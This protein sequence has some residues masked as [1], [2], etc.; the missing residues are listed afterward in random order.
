[1][2][3]NST[4]TDNMLSINEKAIIKNKKEIE[5]VMAAI[6]NGLNKEIMKDELDRLEAEKRK[7]EIE[8]IRLIIK[9]KN[10]PT[11][12]MLLA[13][14]KSLIDMNS[15]TESQKKRL[16]QRFVKKSSSI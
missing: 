2:A 8:N 6:R 10:K 7:L 5:N 13:F 16:I 14:L 1:M 11:P 12:K 3:Y 15:N 9:N 4:V